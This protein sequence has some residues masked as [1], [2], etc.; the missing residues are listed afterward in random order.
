MY[1]ILRQ[2]RSGLGVRTN[3]ILFQKGNKCEREYYFL[4]GHY[5]RS[6]WLRIQKNAVIRLCRPGEVRCTRFSSSSL[7]RRRRTPPPHAAV[8]ASSSPSAAAARHRCH[9]GVVRFLYFLT[10]FFWRGRPEDGARPAWSVIGHG[11]LAGK[12][13]AEYRDSLK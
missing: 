6:F 3:N 9:P 4:R 10:F 11:I 7:R 1:H 2:E 8:V 13:L 5:S 12:Y